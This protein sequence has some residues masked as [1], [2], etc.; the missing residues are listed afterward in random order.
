MA[1]SVL[2]LTSHTLR[3]KRPD[4]DLD[5]DEYDQINDR[6]RRHH[7]HRLERLGYTVTLQSK[8]VA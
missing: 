8:E 1:L 7:G 6:S 5:P 3:D 2:A 4:A